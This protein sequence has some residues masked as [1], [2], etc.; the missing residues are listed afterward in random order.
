VLFPCLIEALL[1]P[2]KRLGIPVVH[3]A[4]QPDQATGYVRGHQSLGQ[5][6]ALDDVSEVVFDL[7][8]QKVFEVEVGQTVGTTARRDRVEVLFERKL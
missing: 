3:D 4:D 8:R 2:L 5:R 7:R 1:K 6:G